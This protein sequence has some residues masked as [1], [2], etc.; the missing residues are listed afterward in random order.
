MPTTMSG[1][2]GL[3]FLEIV[4]VVQEHR[5]VL[6]AGRV[7]AEERHGDHVA[8]VLDQ[9]AHVAVVGVIVVG[10]MTH[11]DVR[12][13]LADQPDDGLAV[14]QRRHQLAVMDVEHF[15]LDAEDL[16]AVA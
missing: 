10:P 6:Q 7:R 8:G 5:V 13:P 16:G 12:P 15:R 4:L 14:L 9:Q 2:N 1:V 11:D 3:G